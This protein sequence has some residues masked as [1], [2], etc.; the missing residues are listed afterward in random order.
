MTGLGTQ[1][2][3]RLLS[4]SDDVDSP[5][6]VREEARAPDALKARLSMALN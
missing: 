4:P 5:E 2:A 6:Q 1:T 3:L